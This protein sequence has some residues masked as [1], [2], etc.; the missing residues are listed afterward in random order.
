MKISNPRRNLIDEDH[1]KIIRFR[2][3][4]PMKGIP[5]SRVHI[6]RLVKAGRFPLHINIGD[7]TIGWVEAEVDEWLAERVA[8]RDA[9]AA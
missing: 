8:E 4:E 1:M 9:K 3:L 5:W 7:A 6:A 2:D